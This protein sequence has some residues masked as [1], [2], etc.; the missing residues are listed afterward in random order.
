MA[1]TVKSI[2]D[3][4]TEAT[5]RLLLDMIHRL[6]L[7]YGLWFNEVRHQMGFE[8]AME[9]LEQASERSR[10]IQLQRLSRL[11]DFEVKS[12][13]PAALMRMPKEGL[14]E[15]MDAIA[16][17]W[18]ANDGVWFQAVEGTH[19][20]NE[21]KRCNDSCWA[22]FSPVEAWSIKRLLALPD[23]PGLEGL[24][25]ALNFRL[26][27]RI[28][29]QSVVDDG[30]EGFTFQMN[31][32]RVQSARK[33]KGL[34]D[35][36]CKSGGLAEYTY[37]ASTIDPR[38]RTVCVACPPDEHPDEWYCAWRFSLAERSESLRVA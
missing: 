13:M 16:V 28:N 35:Y 7:H 22:R 10:D 14:L 15:L 27:A 18:L 38:I 33:R 12:G 37:F 23:Y 4:D 9:I 26:Y 17:N 34:A 8:K 2:N 31:K 20:M 29:I 11:L 19:G 5:V 3:L 6:V 36:P 25:T 30:P 21:A 32:C 1:D 24:K